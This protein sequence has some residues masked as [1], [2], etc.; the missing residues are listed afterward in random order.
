VGQKLRQTAG[1]CD[2]VEVLGQSV[3]GGYNVAVGVRGG[4]YFID[5]VKDVVTQDGEDWVIFRDH[6]W[7]A[8]SDIEECIRACPRDADEL[9]S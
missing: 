9:I 6:A 1:R 2:F 5:R 3:A 4:Q 8:V 7:V